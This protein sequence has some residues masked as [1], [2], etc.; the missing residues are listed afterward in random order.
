MAS[1]TTGGGGEDSNDAVVANMGNAS[2]STEGPKVPPLIGGRGGFI[3]ADL[4]PIAVANFRT[5]PPPQPLPP[6]AGANTRGERDP[7]LQLSPSSPN[8]RLPDDGGA[9][10]RSSSSTP[11][12]F[13][14]GVVADM[15]REPPSGGSIH[16][17]SDGDHGDP[18]SPKPMIPSLNRDAIFFTQIPSLSFHGQYYPPLRGFHH[19]HRRPP[20]PALGSG[21]YRFGRGRAFGHGH[22]QPGVLGES[23]LGRLAS[24]HSFAYHADSAATEWLLRRHVSFGLAKFSPPPQRIQAIV[25][26]AERKVGQM[27]EIMEPSTLISG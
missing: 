6:N 4:T 5:A 9:S 11:T 13:N 16:D 19:S 14:V 17:E 23:R 25:P 24:S 12:E 10:C 8:V 21:L 15:K 1:R 2:D 20:S 7:L 22:G 3:L 18:T 26:Q 27:A